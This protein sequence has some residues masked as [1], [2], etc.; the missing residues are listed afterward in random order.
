MLSAKD[1]DDSFVRKHTHHTTGGAQGVKNLN[2]L[3]VMEETKPTKP[4]GLSNMR[5]LLPQSDSHVPECWQLWDII[6]TP[7]HWV[8]GRGGS[9]PALHH[10]LVV[11]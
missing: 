5:V 8:G 11:D 7:Y 3:T 1:N 6:P 9:W 10:I 4:Q 2:Y